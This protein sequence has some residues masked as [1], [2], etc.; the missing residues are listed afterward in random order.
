M[1][2][3]QKKHNSFQFGLDQNPVKM[4]LRFSITNKASSI[5][6]KWGHVFYEFAFY[7]AFMLL[8]CHEK[9]YLICDKI[10]NLGIFTQP[11]PN[12]FLK[13]KTETAKQGR[14]SCLKKINIT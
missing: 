14:D 12:I 1:Y 5:E 7:F 10:T 9:S 8:A 11:I 13:Y 6:K 3:G 2:L 4:R